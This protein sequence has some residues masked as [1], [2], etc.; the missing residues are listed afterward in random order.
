MLGNTFSDDSSTR[1]SG[2]AAEAEIDPFKVKD[3]KGNFVLCFHCGLSAAGKREII[4][5]DYC[6]LHWHLDCLDPP[7]ANPPVRQP[8]DGRPRPLWR[9]PAHAT[10]DKA[11]YSESRSF[12]KIRRPRNAKVMDTLLSRGL[13]NNGNIEIENDPSDI[14][15]DMDMYNDDGSIYRVTEKS[16]KLDFIERINRERETRHEEERRRAEEAARLLD[17]QRQANFDFNMRSFVDQRAALSLLELNQE[18]GQSNG[19]HIASATS[20]DALSDDKLQS[21]IHGLIAEAPS[22]VL[23]LLADAPPKRP[24]TNGSVPV[25]RNGITNGVNSASN[26]RKPLGAYDRRS[27]LMLR[28]MLS[29]RLDETADEEMISVDHPINGV[30]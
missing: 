6:G 1:A 30:S 7:P 4:K 27:L 2:P 5:C 19:R 12:H 24:S 9:C 20:E 18:P 25:S 3:S 13:K 10:N 23:A 14:E 22:E 17:A 16:V 26:S 11:G 8:L 28:D 21:L 15:D 29:K